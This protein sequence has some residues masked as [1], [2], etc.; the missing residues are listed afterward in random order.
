MNAERLLDKLSDAGLELR[1]TREGENRTTCPRCARGPSD[2]ALAVRI[3][4]DRAC[5]LCHRCQWSGATSANDDNGRH[6]KSPLLPIP[7]KPREAY[8]LARAIWNE[9]VP[10]DG[11]AG[12]DYLHQ[13]ACAFPGRYA[14]LR[15][16]ASLFCTRA[17]RRLPAIVCRVSTAV[18]NRGVGIH[19][20]FLDPAGSDRAI[21]KMRLGSADDPVC[22]RLFADEDISY[23]LAIAEGVETA[24]AAA[25]LY[26]PVWATIDAGQMAKFPVLA[27]I[28]TLTIFAD[29]DPAG[30][31]AARECASRWCAAQRR[32]VAITPARAGADAND[33]VR[34]AAH[35]N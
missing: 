7:A 19:R 5:W 13:R 15:F 23:G 25:R 28:E 3:Q 33:L 16:H 9:C 18:G 10:L 4:G 2:D 1:R 14:D 21:A 22:I 6:W 30:L 34:E 35:A 26:A 29:H 17:A 20:I 12:A 8:E 32:V 31:R 24:L 11:T 27:G